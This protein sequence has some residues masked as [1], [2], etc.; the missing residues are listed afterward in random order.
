MHKVTVE[1]ALAQQ[2]E[3]R[4][5]ALLS[6]ARKPMVGAKECSRGAQE[7]RRCADRVRQRRGGVLVVGLF[8]GRVEGIDSVGPKHLAAS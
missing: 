8:D 5:E 1:Q 6:P 2:L 3:Y 7:G 4:G